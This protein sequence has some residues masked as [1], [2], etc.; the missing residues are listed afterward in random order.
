MIKIDNHKLGLPLQKPWQKIITVGRAYELLR[1]DLLEHLR[2]AQADVGW[3]YCR[4]HGLF[5]DDMNVSVREKNGLLRFQWHHVDKVFDALLDMGLRP[6]IELNPMP[7]AMARG[8]RTMFFFNMN[9][10]P[11]KVWD[12]WSALVSSLAEHCIL[13]YGLEEVRH[14]FFEHPNEPYFPTTLYLKP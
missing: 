6:F 11:P 13:I 14:C 7:S 8:D 3:E 2:S 5:H 4:F 12:E 9:V 1:E 10:T